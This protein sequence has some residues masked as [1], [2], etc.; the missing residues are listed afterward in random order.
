MKPKDAK[1]ATK[2]EEWLAKQILCNLLQIV[3]PY[4]STMSLDKMLVI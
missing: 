1:H 2:D 4:L 3:Q